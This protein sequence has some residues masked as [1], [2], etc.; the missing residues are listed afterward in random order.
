MLTATQCENWCLG[1]R[2]GKA[3]LEVQFQSKSLKALADLADSWSER[4]NKEVRERK[5]IIKHHTTTMHLW[6]LE[7]NRYVTYVTYC[8]IMSTAFWLLFYLVIPIFLLGSSCRSGSASWKGSGGRGAGFTMLSWRHRR[9]GDAADWKN[10]K[11]WWN[12]DERIY[13]K[14]VSVTFRDFFRN[15]SFPWHHTWCKNAWKKLSER[16]HVDVEQ[17]PHSGPMLSHFCQWGIWNGLKWW[18]ICGSSF[19][20]K[21]LHAISYDDH[22]VTIFNFPSLHY[23]GDL[24]KSRPEAVAFPFRRTFLSWIVMTYIEIV[25]S[26]RA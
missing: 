4:R 2:P 8:Q 13:M 16:L 7:M 24:G 25:K 1:F 23:Q 26:C 10:M 14:D 3:C 9:M 22:D 21:Q 12:S 6:S 20:M 15:V 17:G 5:S 19:T 11:E 18:F